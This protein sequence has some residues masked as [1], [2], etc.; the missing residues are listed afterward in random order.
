MLA[1][2]AT[3]K[4]RQRAAREI[5]V[6]VVDRFDASS[7]D[8]RQ[9]APSKTEHPAQHELTKDRLECAAIVAPEAGRSA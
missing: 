5:A 6:V 9:L 3:D 4:L 7:V 2:S 8:G 1:V